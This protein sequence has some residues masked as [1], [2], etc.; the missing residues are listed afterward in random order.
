M[1]RLQCYCGEPLETDKGISYG[2]AG[3]TPHG[4]HSAAAEKL[5]VVQS[6]VGQDLKEDVNYRV[7]FSFDF[8]RTRI[9]FL[10]V[11]TPSFE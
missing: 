5:A 1:Q 11:P 6:E 4:C 8:P 10:G 2:Y 9:S 3:S 7:Q